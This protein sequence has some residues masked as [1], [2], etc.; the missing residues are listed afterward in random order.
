MSIGNSYIGFGYKTGTTRQ[1]IVMIEGTLAKLCGHG[2][3]ILKFDLHDPDSIPRLARQI[4][5]CVRRNCND[6]WNT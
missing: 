6:C 3:G 2:T 5:I 4:N 1:K